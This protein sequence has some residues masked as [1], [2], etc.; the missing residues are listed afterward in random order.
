MYLSD[1]NLNL[2]KT[3]NFT[4][5]VTSTKTCMDYLVDYVLDIVSS[6]P[7]PY[8]LFVSGGV[9]SQAMLYVWKK[10]GVEFNAIH[11]NYDGLND[12]DFRECK[13]FC[14]SHDIQVTTLKFDLLNFLENDLDSYARKYQC[15][16]PQICTH[17]AFSE[18]VEGTKI[19]SGNLPSEHYLGVDNTI[20][21]LQRYANLSGYSVIPFFL[22][23]SEMV[24]NSSFIL[25]ALPFPRNLSTYQSKC[26]R[27]AFI[28]I[29]IV[30]QVDKLTGFEKVKEYY[31]QFSDRVTSKMKMKHSRFP[32]KRVFDQLFRNKYLLEFDNHYTPVLFLTKN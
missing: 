20:F 17:M 3:I 7:P 6:Y 5:D 26:A 28:G 25:S 15:A 19:F 13:F 23:Q 21:G 16:S 12:Y 22:M 10:A 32:S 30:P 1:D 9:D 27:Y 29:P 11:V 2:N 8:N 4:I 24:I 18:L 14:E 31:D